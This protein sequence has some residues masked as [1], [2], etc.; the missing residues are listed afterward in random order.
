MRQDDPLWSELHAGVLTSRLLL[1]VLGMAEGRAAA[2]LGLQPGVASHGK[3]VYAAHAL[4]EAE[5]VA[6]AAAACTTAD[7]APVRAANARAT[8]DACNSGAFVG[9]DAG[10]AGETGPGHVSPARCEQ[11]L[12]YSASRD[13][14]YRLANGGADGATQVAGEGGRGD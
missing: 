10:K 1:G 14:P 3:A 4:Q 6:A 12:I 5:A 11:P 9:G 13:R 2:A 7:D 8:I